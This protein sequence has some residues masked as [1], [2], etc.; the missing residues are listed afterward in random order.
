MTTHRQHEPS[1]V[2]EAWRAVAACLL[3]WRHYGAP[4]A[5]AAAWGTT[6][7]AVGLAS[8]GAGLF[9]V[10]SGF[11]LAP[12]L[13]GR[14]L[15]LRGY[16][17]RRFFRIFPGYALAL[18]LWM[19][20]S[21]GISSAVAP[22]SPPGFWS[23]PAHVEF[24]LL[25]PVL[26]GVA[27]LSD[28]WWGPRGR[29]AWLLAVLG[30]AVSLRLALVWEAPATMTPGVSGLVALHHLPGVLVEFLLG[31]TAWHISTHSLSAF[32]SAG[33][34]LVGLAG[35]GVLGPWAG[36]AANYGFLAGPMSGPISGLWEPLNALCLA[37]MVAGSARLR[38]AAAFLGF[39]GPGASVALAGL[40]RLVLWCG[41]LSYGVALLHP[42]AW[43]W[44]QSM[45]PNLDQKESIPVAVE[46]TLCLAVVSRVAWERPW[47]ALGSR[48]AAR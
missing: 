2:L 15:H 33:L 25:L 42:A 29:L 13:W 45:A 23:L 26:A 27:G 19:G 8:T 11:A 38:A 32:K 34:V 43:S 10:I 48:L 14:R 22:Q 36:V 46:L 44:A 28:Y 18:G 40:R 5:A 21:M 9:F 47:Q 39:A 12:Y 41:G 30:A 35:L 16:A 3:V 4:E 1:A 37:L 24:C 17:L 31:A 6:G 7:Q 20:V